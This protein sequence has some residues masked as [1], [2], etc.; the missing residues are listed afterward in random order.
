MVFYEHLARLRKSLRDSQNGHTKPYKL[1]YSCGEALSLV[2]A[3]FEYVILSLCHM[4]T[5]YA[6]D[7]VYTLKIF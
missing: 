2:P 1:E 4:L 5:P 3:W 7:L 6:H